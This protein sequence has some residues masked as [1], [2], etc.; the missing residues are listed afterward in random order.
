MDVNKRTLSEIFGVSERTLTE[1]QREGLPVKTRADRRGQANLYDTVEVHR[2]LLARAVGPTTTEGGP[3][4]LDVER[5]RLAHHQA[6]LA[7]IEEAA[8]LRDLIPADEVREVVG[9]ALTTAR[10]ILLGIEPRIR[11]QFGREPAAAV[12]E[13]IDRALTELARGAMADN[14]P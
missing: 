8:R 6:N 14:S 11:A 7:G 12:R 13:E 9:R 4:R 1:W 2:W 5:A 10:T 3:L